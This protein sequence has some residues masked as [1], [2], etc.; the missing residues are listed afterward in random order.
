M[1]LAAIQPEP[2]ACADTASAVLQSVDVSAGYT[3]RPVIHDV[4]CQL[5]RGELLGI[6]G[7]NGCGKSTLLKTLCGNLIPVR[8]RVL[9]DDQLLGS[10]ARRRRARMLAMLPQ[11]PEAPVGMTVRDLVRCGRTPH[12]QWFEPFGPTDQAAIGHALHRCELEELADR[13]LAEI[14]GGERQRAW[15]AM[16]LAQQTQVLLL[17]EP[18]SAL[19]IGY[20]LDVMHLLD[21]LARKRRLAV[22]VV[23]HDISLAVRY[24]DRMLV[25][26]QGRVV[27]QCETGPGTDWSLLE[28][29]FRVAI[30]AGS[31]TV[32]DRALSFT[33]CRSSQ[34]CVLP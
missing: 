8:G 25:M 29:V 16:T 27:G 12:S 21:D 34:P 3:K 31:S 11:H 20:Q 6:V 22:A 14:S 30:H 5:R 28:R 18:T 10:I 9:L 4:S 23:M 7:P 13:P 2:V 26:D 17:D 19:D 24:C 15:I 33:R 1:T 32:D